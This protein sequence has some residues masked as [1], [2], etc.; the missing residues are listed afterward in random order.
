MGS[1]FNVNMS[2]CTIGAVAFG[3]GAEAK[4]S[5]VTGGRRFEKHDDV[6]VE[7]D[8]K[9]MMPRSAA[10][11]L[12]DLVDRLEAGTADTFASGTVDGKSPMGCAWTVTKAD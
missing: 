5:V 2:E 7:V 6:N 10:R 9:G 11:L 4:G 12:R 3:A 1:E 8:I